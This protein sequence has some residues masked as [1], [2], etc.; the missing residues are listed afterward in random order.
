MTYELPEGTRILSA[1]EVELPTGEC[2]RVQYVLA[3]FVQGKAPELWKDLPDDERNWS[4]LPPEEQR[5]MAEQLRDAIARGA[6]KDLSLSFDPWGEDYFLSVDFD[7]G[8]AAPLYNACDECGAAPYDPDRPD[9]WEDAPVDIGGQTPVPKMYA[10]EDMEKAARVI[11]CFLETGKL[12]S[13]SK[14]AVNSQGGL[15]L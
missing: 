15:P 6:V 12:S 5:R 10:L 3:D 13:E 8:W 4:S 2:S 9:G 7:Q 1:G 14:W 11:L